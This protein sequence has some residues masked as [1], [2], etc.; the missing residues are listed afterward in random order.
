MTRAATDQLIAAIF[1][2]LVCLASSTCS[3]AFAF[4]PAST[5]RIPT[6]S[7]WSPTTRI[8]CNERNLPGLYSHA[9]ETEEKNSDAVVVSE[10]GAED[11]SLT[12]ASSS[13]VT[14]DSEKDGM[15]EVSD[16]EEPSIPADGYTFILVLCFFVT[17][18]SAL[19]RVAMSVALVPISNEF[20]LTDTVKGQVSSVFSVGYGLAILPCG[21]LVAAA[22]PRLIM[23][24]GVALWS[25]ATLGTP[26]A[27]G[28]IISGGT[29]V[30]EGAN[31]GAAMTTTF[32]AENVAP[33][34]AVRAVM[35][36]SES[37]VL[38]SVQVSRVGLR[39]HQLTTV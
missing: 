12:L 14:G 1:T 10:N 24:A 26:L 19:D 33:L 3:G 31:A 18:L 2:I 25:A 29:S 37:V 16:E 39:E 17:V 34:L 30:I 13:S 32:A 28:L 7:G 20:Y 8:R 5:I 6:K 38:P 9:T 35:G 22:S 21:L 15:V 23:A 11:N 27:A 36:A 4:S